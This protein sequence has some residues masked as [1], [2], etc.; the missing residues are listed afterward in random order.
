VSRLDG[1]PEAEREQLAPVF[2]ATEAV[3]GFVPNSF[4]AMAHWPEL[5]QTFS[6]MAGN[7]IGGGELPRGLKQ[8][9]AFV[10]SNASGCRYC[11]A[12]TAHNAVRAGI[13]EKKLQAAFEFE[14]SNLFDDAERAALR[15][16]LHAGM[17]PNAVEDEQFDALKAHYSDREIVEI[18]SVI[19]L[20]GFLNRWNDTMATPLEAEAIHFAEKAIAPLGWQGGKHLE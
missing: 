10:S 7:I 11:Q 5:L 12:H 20:F 4:Y 17:T 15:V 14:T 19:S 1:L 6:A 3:M 13:D 9:V 16:A 18:V 8:L 2:S